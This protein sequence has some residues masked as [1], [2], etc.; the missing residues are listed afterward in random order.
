MKWLTALLRVFLLAVFFLFAQKNFETA[1][2]RFYFDLE[3]R[4]PLILMLLLFFTLG[5]AVALVA[6]L[7]RLLRYRRERAPAGAPGGGVPGAGV[8]AA[9]RE[10]AAAGGRR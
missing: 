8:P 7:P 1:T 2:L 4:A 6:M 9:A 5:I 10:D 3:W